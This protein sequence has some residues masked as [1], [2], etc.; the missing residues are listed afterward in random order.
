MENHF[1]RFSPD[2][3]KSS[4]GMQPGICFEAET[5]VFKCTG[6]SFLLRK[7]Y[8]L[9]RK[10]RLVLT[11]QTNPFPVVVHAPSGKEKPGSLKQRFFDDPKETFSPYKVS[12]RGSKQTFWEPF[13]S[14]PKTQNKLNT[15]SF[16]T[17]K[18]NL[19]SASFS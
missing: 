11:G 1:P 5:H 15:A 4:V 12:F 13:V 2:I 7:T 19:F 14:T 9:Q 16:K 3:P 6:F 18:T 8:V 17:L 10:K